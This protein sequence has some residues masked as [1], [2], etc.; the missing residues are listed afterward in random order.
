[1][2]WKND[3]W[4]LLK[5]CKQLLPRDLLL[6]RS[7]LPDKV[8]AAAEH[9]GRH[10]PYVRTQG[11]PKQHLSHFCGQI[12]GNTFCPECQHMFYLTPFYFSFGITFLK[13]LLCVFVI[14]YYAEV[15]CKLTV[16]NA[17]IKCCGLNVYG[18][19]FFEV[20]P[21]SLGFPFR[22]EA[23]ADRWLMRCRTRSVRYSCWSKV[24]I[25]LADASYT[26]FE[27]LRRPLSPQGES[28]GILLNC[29]PSP[30]EGKG[31]RDSGGWGVGHAVSVI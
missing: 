7:D 6:F 31:D 1:M 16:F 18:L 13:Y 3:N 5:D 12:Y 15:R 27:R 29:K 17:K 23:V 10:I 9:K 14:V 20:L 28:F 26:S 22:G 19:K 4:I 11:C 24:Y 25:T 21:D 30:L 8:R 2:Y